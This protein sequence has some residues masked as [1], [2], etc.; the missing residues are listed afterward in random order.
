MPDP[1]TVVDPPTLSPL[2]RRFGV[3]MLTMLDERANWINRRVEQVDI[4][5]PATFRRRQSVDFTVPLGLPDLIGGEGDKPVY[6]IPLAMVRKDLLSNFSVWAG[7]SPCTILTRT[8]NSRIAAATLIALA[9][10][11]MQAEPSEDLT[12]PPG[13]E[14][15]IWQIVSQ[16]HMDAIATWDALGSQ[17][18]SDPEQQS[19]VMTT[20][21]T[22]RA[23]LDKD[24]AF[25]RLANDLSRN[26]LLLVPIEARPGDRRVVKYSYEQRRDAPLVQLPRPLRLA[27]WLVLMLLEGP[28]R[29][30]GTLALE[31]ERPPV[32][33]V[34]RLRR[35]VLWWPASV[36]IDAP[37]AT[38]GGSYHLEV[39]A[40]EGLQITRAILQT[41]KPDKVLHTDLKAVSRARLYV[42]VRPTDGLV[43]AIVNLRP[44]AETVIRAAVLSAVVTTAVL[45]VV[46]VWRSQLL[47]NFGTLTTLLLTVP[48]ALAAYTARSG[49]APTTSNVLFGLR[50]L[51]VAS[52][53]LSLTALLVLAAGHTCSTPSP[54]LVGTPSAAHAASTTVLVQ[55]GP[56]CT[57]WHGTT[58]TMA[59][60]TAGSA[61]IL[62]VLLR[63]LVY[64][65]RPPERQEPTGFP[66]S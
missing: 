14:E 31:R 25:L 44:L 7:S 51:V 35:V 27:R 9:R 12:A 22:W 50:W 20:E 21:Q 15:S 65:S 34:S 29:V 24:P 58:V 57:A 42:D 18:S 62:L 1:S 64:T 55:S 30:K 13:I 37:I 56:V 2:D 59:V 11:A 8:Q 54:R 36:E 48:V 16:T 60:L 23:T 43:R 41:R 4:Q 32:A 10:R 49:E 33:F 38:Q 45:G 61:L 47:Q 63:S 6:Y 46:V 5:D 40:P 19:Q 26:F 17:A 39:E 66:K 28:R 53:L 52:G 3:V